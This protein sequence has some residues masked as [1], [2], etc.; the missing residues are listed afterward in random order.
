MNPRLGNTRDIRKQMAAVDTFFSLLRA[1]DEK[2]EM[3]QVE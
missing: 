2:S 3:E 1:I